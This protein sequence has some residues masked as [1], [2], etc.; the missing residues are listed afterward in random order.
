M[1]DMRDV[2]RPAWQEAREE[3]RIPQNKSGRPDDGNTPEYREVVELF[4][5][6]PAI[7][8]RLRTFSEKPFVVRDKILPVLERRHHGVRT[9]QHAP[10]S[11]DSKFAGD[12]I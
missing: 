6:R 2:D 11:F 5:V 3:G 9:E 10:E 4:P 1:N 12:R 8:R 7:E